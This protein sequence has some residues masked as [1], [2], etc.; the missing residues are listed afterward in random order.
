MEI[1]YLTVDYANNGLKLEKFILKSVN[2]YNYVFLQKLIRTGQIRVNQKRVKLGYSLKIGDSIRLPLFN[3]DNINTPRLNNVDNK[4]LSHKKSLLVD[5]LNN[6]I[7]YQD[8][9]ILAI[10][11]PKNLA[12]QGGKGIKISLDNLLPYINI[13]KESVPKNTKLE[14]SSK[15]NTYLNSECNLKI[16]HRLDKETSGVLLLAKTNAA[17]KWLF[18]QF[19]EQKIQKTYYCI[20]QGAIKKTGVIE[21]NLLKVNN[22]ANKVT[23]DSKGKAAVTE[24]KSLGVSTNTYNSLNNSYY[25]S[26]LQITPKSGRNHQIRAHLGLVL[27]APIVG[28]YKYGFVPMELPFK[29]LKNQIFLHAYSISFNNLENKKITVTASLNFEWLDCLH[30]LGLNHKN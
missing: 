5:C 22:A 26:Y 2:C 17:A 15:Y 13:N 11:K 6:N 3:L 24:Y 20:V 9:H 28:D 18:N 12:V 25:V 19:K 7:L 10:N 21:A 23:I 1:K 14:D 16:V 30:K 8:R 29:L 27:K 4:K